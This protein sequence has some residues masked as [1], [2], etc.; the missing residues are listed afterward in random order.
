[1]AFDRLKEWLGL[2]R[3]LIGP[4][5]EIISGRILPEGAT[6]VVNHIAE[7]EIERLSPV[8]QD[9]VRGHLKYIVHNP[10]LND[11]PAAHN[12]CPIVHKIVGGYL[13]CYIWGMSRMVLAKFVSLLDERE[14]GELRRASE[15][16]VLLLRA[17]VLPDADEV[18]R[19]LERFPVESR[20]VIRHWFLDKLSAEATAEKLRTTPTA[21]RRM[22]VKGLEAWGDTLNEYSPIP[23][24]RWKIK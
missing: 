15:F 22:L 11:G 24:D 2:L 16:A 10:A 14:R 1:M 17:I 21:V 19:D 20:D 6:L 8:E 5:E 13:Y 23:L 12:K 7:E 3:G 4:R 9:D 18:G